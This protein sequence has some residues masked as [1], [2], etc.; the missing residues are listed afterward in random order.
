MS[1]NSFNFE[2]FKKQIAQAAQQEAAGQPV[3]VGGVTFIG[4][5]VSMET[6]LAT[7]RIPQRL[8]SLLSNDPDTAEASEWTVADLTSLGNFARMVIT[9]AVVRPK[10]VYDDRPL[11]AGEISVADL[12]QGWLDQVYQWA[13][14]GAA[15]LPVE[16][17]GGETSVA[18][19]ETFPDNGSGQEQSAGTGLHSP[20]IRPKAKR[21]NRIKRAGD[22]P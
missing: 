7:G 21:T 22:S 10:I 20:Q 15:N 13:L 4:R 14:H 6:Y 5:R 17:V 11:K 8:A 12:P 16:T 2:E 19:L 18:A 3:T 1:K 9:D